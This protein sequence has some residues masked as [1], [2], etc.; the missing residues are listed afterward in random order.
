MNRMFERL[1]L[2]EHFSHVYAKFGEE[3]ADDMT[4]HAYEQLQAR[5]RAKRL[6]QAVKNTHN[7]CSHTTEAL[8][9]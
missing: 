1:R 6:Q 5:Q 7:S 4:A 2:Q 9:S 3:I 8:Q